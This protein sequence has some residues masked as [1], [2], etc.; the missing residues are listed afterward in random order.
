MSNVWDFSSA[1]SWL[2]PPQDISHA[3]SALIPE[4]DNLIK[5][6]FVFQL[7]QVFGLTIKSVQLQWTVWGGQV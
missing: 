5:L 7:F 2:N 3:L 4:N 6:V 1:A